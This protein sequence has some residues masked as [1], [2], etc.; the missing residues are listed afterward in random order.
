LF[1]L[2]VAV[3]S[4]CCDPCLCDVNGS[5]DVTATDA[6]AGLN[7]AVGQPVDLLCPPCF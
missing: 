7:A 1:T 3:G 2:N 5:G 6:L 4:D